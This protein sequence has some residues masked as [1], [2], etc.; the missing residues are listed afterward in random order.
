MNTNGLNGILPCDYGYASN[1]YSTNHKAIDIGWLKQYSKN[2]KDPVKA[3]RE[4]KVIQAGKIKETINGKTYY[5]IVVV[6]QHNIQ[7]KRLFT[8]YWHLD[9]TNMK[10]GQQVKTGD[11]IGIRGNTGYA[12]GVHLHFEL[13]ICPPTT[14]Y[15]QA[16][17]PWTR[18]NVNP[19][20]YTFIQPNQVFVNYAYKLQNIPQIQIIATQLRK[21]NKP[22]LTGNIL[23]FCQPN[24]IYYVYDMITNDGY[25]WAKIDTDVWIA[26]KEGSWTK[27]I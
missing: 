20:Q 26:T 14:T 8:R 9:S 10:V 15:S 11:I 1:G 6:L 19:I 16:S 21:R 5:P 13:K 22:S 12:T 2:G 17:N 3:F 7:N 4:G 25:V 27:T 23:G 18:Y 24:D